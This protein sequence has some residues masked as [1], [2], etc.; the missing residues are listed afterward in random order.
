MAPML[1]SAISAPLRRPTRSPS[2]RA[3]DF[4][5]D[6]TWYSMT[7]VGGT[8][9]AIEQNHGELDKVTTDGQISRVVDISA[10]QGHIVPTAIAYHDGNFY[11]GNL[12]TFPIVGDSK[13]SRSPRV[14]RSASWRPGCLPSWRRLRWTGSAL[15]AG[16][17]Y[18]EESG[19]GAGHGYVVRMTASGAWETVASGLFFPTAMTFGP[20]GMLYVS[21]MGFGPPTGQIVKVN[22]NAAPTAAPSAPAPAPAPLRPLP[23]PRQWLHRR[24]RRRR[25]AT[26]VRPPSFTAWVTANA[27]LTEQ[28]AGVVIT[29][30]ALISRRS[31]GPG[32]NR[33]RSADAPFGAYRPLAAARAARYALMRS[34][35]TMRWVASFIRAYCARCHSA[36]GRLRTS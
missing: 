26:V 1:R 9:Y 2:R 10:S 22:V 14:D 33:H 25:P 15:R 24:Q 16:N 30:P 19:A 7:N 6:G 12:S 36:G 8:L 3:D 21:N 34:N 35:A 4:E 28:R 5:P 17:E 29:T 23:H 11:V 32:I 13:S 18:R 27:R 20:D 31:F